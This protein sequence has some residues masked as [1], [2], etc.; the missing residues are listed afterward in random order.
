MFEDIVLHFKVKMF[1]DIA[2]HFALIRNF[3]CF[4]FV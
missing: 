3:F 4:Y 2:L 1:E